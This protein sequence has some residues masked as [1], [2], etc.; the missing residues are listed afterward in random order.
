MFTSSNFLFATLIMI[1]K[2]TMFTISIFSSVCTCKRHLFS[3]NLNKDYTLNMNF[4]I[5]VILI[6]TEK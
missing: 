1:I 4:D 5:I 6:D 3:N 2:I